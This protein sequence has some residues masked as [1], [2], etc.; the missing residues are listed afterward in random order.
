MG[1]LYGQRLSDLRDV[2][3][4]SVRAFRKRLQVIPVMAQ[5]DDMSS[6][7]IS[8]HRGGSSQLN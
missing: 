5:D 6:L 4:E 3:G 7:E 2:R 1:G 8:F